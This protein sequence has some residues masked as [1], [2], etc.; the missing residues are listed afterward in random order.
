ML[1]DPGSELS[2]ISENVVQQLQLKRESASIPLLGIGGTYSGRTRGIVTLH[3]QSIHDTSEIC[4]ISAYILSKL[5]TKLPSFYATR[6]NWPHLQGISLADPKFLCPGTIQIIIGADFYGRIIKPEIVKGDTFSPIAQNSIFGWIV[7]GPVLSNKSITQAQGYNCIVDNEL[8][9]LVSRFW[10]QEEPPSTSSSILS[11]EEEECEKHFINTFSRDNS[12]RY[13]VRLPLKL[14]TN[15]LGDSK[16]TA[17]RS[18]SRLSQRFKVD[19][20]YYLRYSEFIQEYE[21]LRHMQRIPRTNI[22]VSPVFYL[23]HHGVLREDNRT[24]KLRVVFNGSSRTSSGMSLNDILLTGANLQSDIINVLLWIRLPR[25]LFSTDIVKM[26]RQIKIHPEDYNLQRIFWINSEEQILSYHLTTIT[27][28]LNCAPFLALR[29]LQQL[30][31]DEGKNFPLAIPCLTKG[32][33]M[34][35]IFGGADTF[36]ETQ[37]IINHLQQLCMAGGFPLQK[38]ASNNKELLTNVFTTSSNNNSSVEIETSLI[39]ILGLHWNS[40]TDTFHFASTSAT[41]RKITKRTILSEIARLFDPLGLLAPVII[42]AK[43]FLQ[44]LWLSKFN[45]DDPLSQIMSERWSTFRQ[46]LKDVDQ[47]SIPRWL[48]FSKTINSVE[49]HGFSDASQLAMA[50][51]VY[52]RVI[53]ENKITVM[54]VCS[55]TKVTPLKK[56]TIPRLELTAALLLAR[57]VTHVQHALELEKTSIQ[58]WTDSSVT[59]TWISSHPSRWKDYVRNRVTTIQELTSPNCWRF[60]PGKENP[61]DCA[62]RGLRADQLK[63]HSLWWNGPTWLSE[64]SSV[65]PSYECESSTREI[66]EERPGILLSVSTKNSTTYWNLLDR[67]S[68]LNRLQRITTICRRIINRFRGKENSSLNIPLTPTELR[69]SLLWWVRVVQQAWFSEEIKILIQNG[70]LPKTNGLIRLTPFLDNQG[71][72]RVGGRLQN[73]ILDPEE[74]HPYILPRTSPLSTLIIAEAHQKTLHGGTQVTLAFL[75]RSFWIIGGRAPVRTYILQCIRCARYRGLRAQQLMGQLPASRIVPSRPFLHTGV[76]YAGPITIKT[77]RGR[78]AKTYKGYLAIFVCFSSS[79]VHLELVTEYSTEAFIAAYKR[80]TGRRGICSFLYSDCGTNF[81]GAD[82]ALRKMFNSTSKE[83]PHLID[84]LANDGTKW[85]FNPPSAPHFGGKW[86][87]A[88][89]STKFHLLRTIGASILTYEELSTLLI[90]I[91]AVLNSRPLCPLSDD[92]E[93]LTALTPGHFLIGEALT[94]IPEPTLLESSTNRL[95]RWQLIRQKTSYF[96][97]RWSSEC[98][99]RYQSISKWHHSSNKIKEGSLVLLT[100]EKYPPAKWPLARVLKLH[101]GS[102]G[103]TRVVTIRTSTTTL[104][105]PIVK[106]SILPVTIEEEYL[107]TSLP[108]AGGMFEKQDEII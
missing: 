41:Q 50:A 25:Y 39:K 21:S 11:P 81:V 12:G 27:Y 93:D 24:T 51:V 106:L 105:R 74:K 94:T 30:I 3:L 90:Q 84:L 108:K 72:L 26:Y 2:F 10:S 53:T 80:F 91:E 78:A 5:T 85:S 15:H 45:W 57:L 40:D 71:F 20:T 54:L 55:K 58:L 36:E 82:A 33:Y 13:I 88:V 92:A 62:S 60:V 69:Q 22:E 46:Q 79:A 34:D 76:D 18:L 100:E 42:R 28:G 4:T 89:K 6:E 35:D 66:L 68:S 1:I 37:K 38:W 29:T 16:K 47:I 95:N 8:N 67:Y 104:K 7:S 107:A 73:S 70:Q 56:H 103:L 83:I 48:H 96:W 86:E 44:E 59:L 9:E 99:Q 64:S 31:T 43:I 52:L 63:K 77:W 102:D 19:P 32:R 75:R 65:W 101:P 14:S 23:P 17:L 61:A 97:D 87:A 49:I 98:L